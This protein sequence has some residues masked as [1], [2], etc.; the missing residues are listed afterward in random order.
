MI[1][2]LDGSLE[3]FQWWL[4]GRG[5]ERPVYLGNVFRPG[6]KVFSMFYRFYAFSVTTGADYIFY[7]RSTYSTKTS[8]YENG[9][10]H[11]LERQDTCGVL[12]M[13]LNNAYRCLHK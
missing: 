2:G 7:Y 9:H 6:C 8:L 11:L 12:E 13:Y 3:A 5:M 1:E 10:P 4:E